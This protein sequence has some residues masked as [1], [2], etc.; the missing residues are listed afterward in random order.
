[1]ANDNHSIIPVG[2][3]LPPLRP[4][5][6][7]TVAPLTNR[8]RPALAEG[9][10]SRVIQRPH[11]NRFGMLNEFVDSGMAELPHLA[12]LVWFVLF[13]DAR[14][15]I[16]QTS[17]EYI[18]KRVGVKRRAVTRALKQLR[19]RG[20]VDLVKKGGLNRGASVHKIQPRGS[21]ECV[22]VGLTR[23]TLHKEKSAPALFSQTNP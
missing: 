9:Q 13:R 1:M 22:N 14:G 4:P 8:P 2:E 10:T 16:A 6:Q 11:S 19:N 21:L 23:P 18:A 20:F 3:E 15:N 12:A 17:S 5:E 7:P